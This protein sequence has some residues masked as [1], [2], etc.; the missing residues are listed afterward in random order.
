VH[1]RITKLFAEFKAIQIL[2]H[3]M[4]TY[5]MFLCWDTNKEVKK[6]VITRR[7]LTKCRDITFEIKKITSDLFLNLLIDL[8]NL[9]TS[10][11]DCN[12]EASIE[13]FELKHN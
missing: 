12:M 1:R 7:E 3:S 9:L 6:F 10:R 5:G 13:R 8:Y 4:L 11:T 2:F